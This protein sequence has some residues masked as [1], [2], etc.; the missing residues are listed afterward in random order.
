MKILLM[1]K[2]L[3]NSVENTDNK[4]RLWLKKRDAFNLFTQLDMH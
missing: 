3:G 4:V 1:D 2:N